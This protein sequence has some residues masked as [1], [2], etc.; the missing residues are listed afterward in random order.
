[1]YFKDLSAKLQPFVQ[2]SAY[3]LGS[4]IAALQESFWW[5]FNQDLINNIPWGPHRV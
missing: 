4:V 3:E 2:A 1:M 5:S